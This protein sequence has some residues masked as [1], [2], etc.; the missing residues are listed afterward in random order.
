MNKEMTPWKRFLNMLKLDRRDIKQILFY[1]IF[2]GLVALTL[3]LGIQAIINLIQ[4]AQVST[5]WIVLVV[6]VTLGVAFQGILQLMQIR[7]LENIQQKIFTRSSFEFAYRFPKIKMSELRDFYPPELANRF[8]DTLTVQKGLSKILLDFPA[9]ILQIVF[10]LM[11]L[12]FYHPFFIIYGFLL[13]ILVYLVFKFTALRGL[14]TSLTESKGKYKVAHWLQEIARS[15]ISFKLSGRTSLAMER[16]NTLTEKYLEARESHFRILVIQFIQMIGFK[17][18]VTAGLLLIG[19]LL[20]LNQQMNIGQFVAA[21]II[22]LLVISSVEKLITGLESFYDVLTSL[23]KIGQ[24]VDKEIDPQVGFDPFENHK[25]TD[26]QIDNVTYA[27]PQTGDILSNIKLKIETKDRLLIDGVSGS[28]KT[29]LLKLIS[30]IIEPTAGAI[31]INDLSLKGLRPNAYRSQIGQVLPEQNPFEGTILE[32]I[33]FGN[34]EISQERLNEVIKIVGLQDFVRQQTN[35]LRTMLFPEGQ[36]IPH[37]ISKRILLARAIVHEPRVLLI[38]DALEH[39]ESTEARAIMDYLIH[40]DRP[41]A[42]AVSSNNKDWQTLCTRY[43]KLE[44]GKIITQKK[45]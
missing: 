4:G 45:N 28:G 42:L 36:Q 22:I 2:A 30:G 13:V 12:S 10:G 16:N 39:F 19:G 8:F 32:N 21:E 34:K 3:P 1:A 38:K 37:T 6:L 29:T 26:I 20:V 40:P 24:V 31:Y 7:I 17:V 35:G 25:D 43:I 44:N 33:T 41:W 9:A 23:E 5:S 15:L 27:T 14:Q 11:L 18:L